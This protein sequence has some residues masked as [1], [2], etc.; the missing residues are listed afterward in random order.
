MPD[1]T[2]GLQTREFPANLTTREADNGEM[3]VVGIGVPYNREIELFPGVFEEFAP[4]S[5]ETGEIRKLFWRHREPLGV[6]V[7]S[8]NEDDGWH[9]ESRISNTTLGRDAYTLARDGA[10]DSFSIGFTPV[11]WEERHDENGIHIRHTKVTG[12]EISLVP[13][14]AY[15]GAAVTEVREHT[16]PPER[17]TTMPDTDTIDLA[18][19]NEQLAELTREIGVIRTE[20]IQRRDGQPDQFRSIGEYVQALVRGD[21]TATRAFTGAVTGD[22]ILKDA[23]IGDVIEIIKRPQKV[24]RTFQFA[25]NLPAQGMT[26]EYGKLKSNTTKV[27]KQENEGDDLAFGKVSITT[28]TAPVGTYGGYTT[29]S[30]QA[31]ERANIGVLDFSFEGMAEAYG[32]AI[33]NLVRSV[34]TSALTV[35]GANALDTVT[36]ALTTQTSVVD[37]LLELAEH[38]EDAGR[39]LDGLYVAKDVFKALYAIESTDRILQVTG[40]GPDKVG[41]LD[42]SAIKADLAA[43]PVKVLP[44]AATGTVLAYDRRSIKTMESPGAPLRLQDEN[45]VNLSKDFSVYGYAASFVQIPSGLVKVT[46]D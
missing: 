25:S 9:H 1:I 21:E 40:A 4:G 17:E 37:L 14:P 11:E 2:T 41:T 20:G 19:I 34:L 7:S 28:E 22:T 23:W 42:V 18:P 16:T 32:W 39:S 31:I 29:L 27:E 12:K 15:D 44:G 3:I 6:V 35:T 10:V 33:E 36:G 38:Y 43:L 5:V 8:S 46:T 24:A 13:I 26:V 30:R 45:I